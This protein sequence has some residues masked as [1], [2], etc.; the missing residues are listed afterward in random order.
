MTRIKNN[1]FLLSI[2]TLFLFLSCLLINSYSN[3]YSVKANDV[4]QEEIYASSNNDIFLCGIIDPANDEHG[5]ILCSYNT[6]VNIDVVEIRYSFDFYEQT[7]NFNY[8]ANNSYNISNGTTY[9]Q[10]TQY[11]INEIETISF[12]L[13]FYFDYAQY[14]IESAGAFTNIELEIELEY[15]LFNGNFDYYYMNLEIP[16]NDYFD[17][18]NVYNLCEYN[19]N[20]IYNVELAYEQGYNRGYR[21][22]LSNNNE[23]L[24]QAYEQGYEDGYNDS[25]LNPMT[26]ISSIFSGINEIFS[27]EIFPEFKIWYLIGAP[28]IV[29][30]IIGVLKFLR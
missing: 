14:P 17:N 7:L 3:K 16:I 22:G 26:F 4:N 12:N 10:T 13:Y 9:T 15:G 19:F 28:L 21:D 29:A 23:N 18:P 5:Y 24:G 25:S 11:T 8:S 6:I 30:L 1:I 2:T 27:V 20:L